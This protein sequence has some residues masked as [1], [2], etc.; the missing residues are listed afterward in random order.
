MAA[1]ARVLRVLAVLVPVRATP[2]LYIILANYTILPHYQQAHHLM[3][4]LEL[5]YRTPP[6]AVTAQL[7]QAERTWHSIPEERTDLTLQ[8]IPAGNKRS[9]SARKTPTCVML[10]DCAD[11]HN[12]SSASNSS[13]ESEYRTVCMRYSRPNVW[14]LPARIPK[15][16]PKG[17]E[18]VH[19]SACPSTLLEH[20]KWQQPMAGTQH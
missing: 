12:D 16:E 17:R 7:H 6:S 15:S 19:I 1:K 2:F 9:R 20:Q 11:S 4:L 3:Q 14:E 5:W 10:S 8:S 18:S 13:S